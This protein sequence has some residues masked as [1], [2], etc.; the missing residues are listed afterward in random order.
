MGWDDLASR[1]DDQGDEAKPWETSYECLVCGE[2]TSG[3]GPMA[4][5]VREKHSTELEASEAGWDPFDS[6]HPER[7]LERQQ[8]DEDPD[9]DPD[10]ERDPDASSRSLEDLRDRDPDPAQVDKPQAT[11]WSLPGKDDRPKPRRDPPSSDPEP[12]DA[13]TRSADREE[14]VEGELKAKPSTSGPEPAQQMDPAEAA[15]LVTSTV[16]VASARL[17]ARGA[18]PISEDEREMLVDAWAPVVAKWLPHYNAEISA[19]WATVLVFGPRIMEAREQAR[20]DEETSEEIEEHSP[21]AH[22]GPDAPDAEEEDADMEARKR[23]FME[24]MAA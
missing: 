12:D 16:K 14:P 24:Q 4:N 10:R 22:T 5:H 18:E 19:A 7:E 3:S 21:Q 11:A 9:P 17:E 1:V 13:G 15:P 8:A 6:Q 20:Q 23:A 2:E